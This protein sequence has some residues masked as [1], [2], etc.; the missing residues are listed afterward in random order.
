MNFLLKSGERDPLARPSPERQFRLKAN[1]RKVVREPIGPA[2]GF[3]QQVDSTR[4]GSIIT[5]L[6]GGLDSFAF[7][8]VR[9]A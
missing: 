8:F 6:R 4:A 3:S 2:R 9:T 7:A 1:F 5:S